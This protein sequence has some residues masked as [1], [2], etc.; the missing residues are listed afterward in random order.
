MILKQGE[1]ITKICESIKELL[2]E[3]Q[4]VNLHAVPPQPSIIQ[5]NNLIEGISLLNVSSFSNLASAM[6]TDRAGKIEEEEKQT[7]LGAKIKK[8]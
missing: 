2:R 8:N 3:T 5:S 6:V 7:L 1:E 4:I